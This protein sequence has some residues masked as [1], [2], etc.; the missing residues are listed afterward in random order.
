MSKLT[1]ADIQA[2]I[3]TVKSRVAQPLM[4]IV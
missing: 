1:D 4:L 2:I 3:T